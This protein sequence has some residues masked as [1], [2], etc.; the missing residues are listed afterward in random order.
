MLPTEGQ[1]SGEGNQQWLQQAVLL[2]HAGVSEVKACL[3]A[4]STS[5]KGSTF[6]LRI[7]SS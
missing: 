3:A 4:P 6:Q 2:I 1:Q 7:E 5:W